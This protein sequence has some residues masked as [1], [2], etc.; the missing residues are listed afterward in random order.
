MSEVSHAQPGDSDSTD[1][2]GLVS[3]SPAERTGRVKVGRNVKGVV[4]FSRVES[5]R[6]DG[7]GLGP[8]GA[9]EIESKLSACQIDDP[10]VRRI[11]LTD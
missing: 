1:G 4:G 9:E 10:F 2:L 7:S 8:L 3:R 6:G 5:R 11:L